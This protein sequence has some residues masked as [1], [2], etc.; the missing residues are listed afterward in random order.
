MFV[1]SSLFFRSTSPEYNLTRQHIAGARSCDSHNDGVGS[2]VVRCISPSRTYTP[3]RSGRGTGN[4]RQSTVE[5]QRLL[6]CTDVANTQTEAF[7]RNNCPFHISNHTCTVQVNMNILR[8]ADEPPSAERQGGVDF[9]HG[10]ATQTRVLQANSTALKR[11]SS[12]L[13]LEVAVVPRFR[14]KP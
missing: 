7:T 6:P 2:N 12:Y 5:N 3:K 9:S 14:Y 13:Q 1:Q 11:D 4:G 10:N 8:S